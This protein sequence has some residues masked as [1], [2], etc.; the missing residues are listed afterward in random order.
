MLE[1]DDT[2]RLTELTEALAETDRKLDAYRK[3]FELVPDPCAVAS[4]SGQFLYVNKA[5][6]NVMDKSEEELTGALFTKF[7]HPDDINKTLHIMGVMTGNQITNFKNRYSKSDGTY[8]TLNW[9]AA[10]WE[11]GLAYA[12]ARVAEPDKEKLIVE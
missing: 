10:R 5:F 9:S 8:V 11:D 7:V 12:S 1:T 6:C 4:A 3:F 2:F